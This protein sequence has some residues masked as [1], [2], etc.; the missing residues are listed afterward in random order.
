MQAIGKGERSIFI[1]CYHCFF[2]YVRYAVCKRRVVNEFACLPLLP[3][4]PY[5]IVDHACGAYLE[6][7]HNYVHYFKLFSGGCIG[8]CWRHVRHVPQGYKWYPQNDNM[9]GTSVY[10]EE[11][12]TDAWSIKFSDIIYDQVGT[13]K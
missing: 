10:G 4:T 12:G 3:P 11:G 9:V 6:N 13:P 5:P 8:A 7:I 2:L 1:S